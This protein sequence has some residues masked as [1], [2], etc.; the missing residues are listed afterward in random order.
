MPSLPGRE[1]LSPRARRSAPAL[2][3]VLGCV[4]ALLLAAFGLHSIRRERALA[5]AEARDEAARHAAQLAGSIE[6]AL[7]HRTL[8]SAADVRASLQAG[9][10]P[11][12][13]PMVRAGTLA[14]FQG[15][16]WTHPAPRGS[17]ASPL[18]FDSATLPAPLRE[19]WE[20]AEKLSVEGAAPH[21][22]I[23]AWQKAMITAPGTAAE[24]LV[25]FR[26]G[27][28]LLAAGRTDEA[29]RLLQ[30]ATH[31]GDLAGTTGVPLE[32]LA[33]RAALRLS[34][35]NPQPIGLQNGWMN[36]LCAAV[37]VRWNLP[38]ALL[39]DWRD[40]FPDLVARWERLAARHETAWR[41]FTTIAEPPTS[42]LAQAA[43]EP[44]WLPHTPTP[45]LLSQQKVDGGTWTLFHT[46]Q[47]VREAV[48]NTL[49]TAP[50]PPHAA[51][52]V[53]VGGRPV[54]RDPPPPTELA[55]AQAS[56]VSVRLGLRDPDAFLSQVEQRSRLSAILLVMTA[57]ITVLAVLLSARAYQR[58]KHL[59]DLQSA[60]VASVS[61]ELR[62]PLA[63]ISLMAE[64]LADTQEP[65]TD[66][67]HSYHRFI[68]RETQRLRL[69]VENVLR[70]ARL[71]RSDIQPGLEL[72]PT[73]LRDQLRHAAALITP[74][75]EEQ[76]VTLRLVLPASPVSAPVEIHA[77]QQVLVNLLDNALKHAPQNSTITLQLLATG[78]A[79]SPRAGITVTDEGPGIP[80]ADQR[81]IFEPFYRRGS[82]LHRETPGIGL[83]LAL[84]R[85]IVEAHCG[86]VRVDSTPGRGARFTVEIPACKP[87][88][89]PRAPRS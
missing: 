21:D 28:T 67:R 45:V 85:R 44:R 88:T 18:V 47:E 59:A 27:R 40:D 30:N 7:L 58:Q 73:D 63:S 80:A 6:N 69:L 1:A 62:A 37:F 61:H 34:A 75:A 23:D 68:V 38:P 49:R 43:H 50:Q 64:E 51:A 16:G 42:N 60:F 81:R 83:G 48:S 82:E 35:V 33:A 15:D 57:A 19:A 24:P 2:L 74:R 13:D 5:L 10:F 14:V 39:E 52:V 20:Q 76:Q 22:Q 31:A 54:T 11:E 17:R 41:W 87:D 3:A 32:V 55:S 8:P 71:E 53:L 66:R 72:E 79:E 70:H 29:R 65:E 86:S 78:P 25:A 36:T 84:T 9:F 26:L 77:F 46:E 4:P 12:G 56:V 89:G